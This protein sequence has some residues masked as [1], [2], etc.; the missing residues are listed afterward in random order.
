MYLAK[1]NRSRKSRILLA[2]GN[3]CLFSGLVM[4]LFN[5]SRQPSNV[6]HFLV[7]FLLGVAIALLVIVALQTRRTKQAMG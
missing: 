1:S 7:G 4:S 2:V 6:S 3:L 5:Q